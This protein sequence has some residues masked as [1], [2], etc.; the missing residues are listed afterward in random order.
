MMNCILFRGK[1][2]A[3]SVAGCQMCLAG[4]YSD[5]IA[6]TTCQKCTAGKASP[7]KGADAAAACVDCPTG[8]YSKVVGASVC[9]KCQEGKYENSTGKSVCTNCPSNSLSAEGSIVQSQCKCKT[10]YDGPNSTLCAVCVV[11]KFSSI[12]GTPTCTSCPDTTTTK[13]TGSD[14]WDVSYR[15]FFVPIKR[16]HARGR[17]CVT[18][19]HSS[20]NCLTH[21]D[22]LTRPL[23]HSTHPIPHSLTQSLPH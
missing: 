21:S 12:A 3:V 17:A 22:C 9:F 1:V 7:A 8:S 18:L 14:A 13:S 5:S 6:S 23:T 15:L 10:G 2:G 11:G 4:S 19:P 16:V 20:T